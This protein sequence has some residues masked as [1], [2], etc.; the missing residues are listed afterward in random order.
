M[1]RGF[2]PTAVAAVAAALLSIGS[3]AARP[4]HRAEH[5]AQPL[6]IN[7]PEARSGPVVTDGEFSPGE[8]EGAFQH[9]VSESC[10]VYLLADS[11]HLYV[12]FRFLGEVEADFVG[13]V[14]LASNDAG[15]LNLHSSG[16]LGE[17]FNNFS[18]DLHRAAFTVDSNTGWES[19][20]TG[21]GARSQGKEFRISRAVLP[22][23]TVKLAGGMMVVNQTMRESASFPA[24]FGFA[25]PDDWVELVLPTGSE[26]E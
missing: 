4:A 15:F 13:E 24:R 16:A 21:A 22:G 20:V 1:I 2:A 17:G 8:W 26:A 25:N 12:G 5:T 14:Y 7:V 9:R 18:P 3:P 19:N 23:P 10:D 11:T 6:R